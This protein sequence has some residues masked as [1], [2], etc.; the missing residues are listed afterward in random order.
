MDI[1]TSRLRTD[2]PIV[3]FEPFR[4]VHAHSTGNRNSTVQVLEPFETTQ[5]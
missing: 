5:L 1:D 2:L 3:G 4:Q